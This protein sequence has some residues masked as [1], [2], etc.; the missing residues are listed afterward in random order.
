MPLSDR[1]LGALLEDVAARSP[2]PGGGAVTGLVAALAAALGRMVLAFSEGKEALAEHA[3][4][5]A[6][7]SAAL[8]SATQQALALA[9]DD[10]TAYATLSKLWKRPADD[11]ERIAALDAAIDVPMRMLVFAGHLLDT[12]APLPGATSAMLASDLGIAAVLAEATARAAHWNL[13]VNLP[14]VQD[15]S[16]RI[17]LAGEAGDLLEAICSK[18]ASIEAACR[19]L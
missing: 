18:S 15:E 10:K 1:P 16:L 13:T 19:G 7:A 2:T 8:R 12:L 11:E 5:H 6:S 3:S 14:Q 17:A 9:D 4:L